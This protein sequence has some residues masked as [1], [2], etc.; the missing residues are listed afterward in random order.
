MSFQQNILD[1]YE[2]IWKNKPKIY[3]WDKG[4]VEKMPHDF[5]I[6]EFEPS[7][8]REMWTY[9]TCCMSNPD[10]ENPIELHFFSSKKDT[11]LI[12]LLTTVVYF[13]RNTSRLN[14][15]HTVNFGRPWQD[16][17]HCDYGLIS[18]PY[19]DGSELE[20]LQEQTYKIKFY[21]L[22]P[23]TKNEVEFKKNYGIEAL[24]LKFEELDLDY[25]NPNRFTIS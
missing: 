12:E 16:K 20:N 8:S 13:H 3:L 11:S 22:I 24:E 9:S 1:H 23:I 7:A 19:L 25:T 14:L 17:S 2:N 6:L 5:R 21:W 4:K 10:D 15:W 18:L